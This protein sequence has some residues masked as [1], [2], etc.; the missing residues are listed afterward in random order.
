MPPE[1]SPLAL[2]QV[3]FIG[4]ASQ[5]FFSWQEERFTKFKRSEHKKEPE[6]HFLIGVNNNNNN[7]TNNNNT[8]NNNDNVSQP[9]FR[10]LLLLCLRLVVG[11]EKPVFMIFNAWTMRDGCFRGSCWSLIRFEC[12]ASNW[13]STHQKLFW[14]AWPAPDLEI[15]EVSTWPELRLWLGEEDWIL[16]KQILWLSWCIL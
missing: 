12:E 2:A 1:L 13:I 8:N 3:S 14:T 4:W 10:I 5:E 16:L 9:T 7:N 6:Q 11:F 15:V